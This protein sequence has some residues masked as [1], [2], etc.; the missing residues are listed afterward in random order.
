MTYADTHREE[1]SSLDSREHFSTEQQREPW[2]S[3]KLIL[4]AASA[5]TDKNFASSEFAGGAGRTYG[6]S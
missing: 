4:L 1:F 5:G 6:P 3:P 2:T